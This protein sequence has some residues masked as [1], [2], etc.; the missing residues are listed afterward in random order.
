MRSENKKAE[1]IVVTIIISIF[2]FGIIPWL[3]CLFEQT[4]NSMRCLGGMYF[5]RWGWLIM[6]AL[7][8]YGLKKMRKWSP[9]WKPLKIT[10]IV[11]LVIMLVLTSIWLFFAYLGYALSTIA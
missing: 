9:T 5:L 4:R 11:F 2:V 8:G 1:I 6:F 7:T 3:L 10:V